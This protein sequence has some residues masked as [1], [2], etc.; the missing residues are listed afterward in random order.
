[1]HI[2]SPGKI[3]D[4]SVSTFEALSQVGVAKINTKNIGEL[5]ASYRLTVCIYLLI[6]LTTLLFLMLCC[7]L[8]FHFTRIIQDQ[9]PCG[10]IIHAPRQ[11]FLIL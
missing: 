10:I 11:C 2:R 4:I 7:Q 9:I 8:I 1:M 5:E 6:E 3:M